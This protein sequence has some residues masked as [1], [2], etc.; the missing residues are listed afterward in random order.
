MSLVLGDALNLFSETQVI[1]EEETDIQK[2]FYISKFLQFTGLGMTSV[3]S[4]KLHLPKVK[5]SL[6]SGNNQFLIRYHNYCSIIFSISRNA[7]F[8]GRERI[9]LRVDGLFQ[10]GPTQGSDQFR[11]RTYHRYQT[12]NC[13]YE[14]Y[15]ELASQ[16]EESSVGRRS[17]RNGW[18]YDIGFSKNDWLDEDE[19]DVFDDN[20]V[21]D[22]SEDNFYDV[23]GN[24][25][26]SIIFTLDLQ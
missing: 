1:H 9:T 11:V 15:D 7:K 19:I 23:D 4:L 13:S 20:F 26:N 21:F 17:Y 12:L 3:K 5:C 2:F 14:P 10:H 16:S 24:K 8:Q 18:L 6:A 22:P 25:I